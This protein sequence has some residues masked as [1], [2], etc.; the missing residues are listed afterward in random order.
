MAELPPAVS[1]AFKEEWP[2]LQIAVVLSPLELG[3]TCHP[4]LWYRRVT[5][6]CYLPAP[7]PMAPCR[8]C[9]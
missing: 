1:P 5:V 6:Q 4:K 2:V 9:C 3:S 7:A 8:R